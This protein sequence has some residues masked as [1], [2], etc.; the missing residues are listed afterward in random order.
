[1]PKTKQ[2]AEVFCSLFSYFELVELRV[3]RAA[4]LGQGRL[5]K[6]DAKV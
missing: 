5:P 4:A 2:E 3:E 1:M 6:T